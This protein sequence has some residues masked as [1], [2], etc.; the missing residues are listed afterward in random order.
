MDSAFFHIPRAL[1]PA[2]IAVLTCWSTS[3][4]AQ[5]Y[6][7]IQVQDAE[8]GRGVPLVEL[9]TVNKMRYVTDSA[10]RVA[11]L[12]PGL[13]G[14][15]VFF[16][17]HAHGYEVP[18]DGFGI[19][20]ARLKLEEGGSVV[21]KLKRKNLAERLYRCTGYG[22]YRDS[23]LLGKS[24]PVAEPLGAGMVAGQDSVLAV[25]YREK[26]Y[27]FWG[28]TGRMSYP[29]GLFR[30]AGATS[31]LPGKGGLAPSIGVNLKYFTAKDGFCRAMADVPN[32]EGV[33][34]I[35]GVCTVR[36]E[37][38]RERLV[39]H[40]SRRKGLDGEYEHGM[41][42]YNDEREIFEVTT[43]LPLTER[44]RHLA[45]QPTKVKVDGREFIYSGGPVLNVRV[46]ATLAEVMDP[47]KYEAWSCVP[48]S[49]PGS[50]WKWG[51]ANP[52]ASKEESRWLKEGKI[53]AADVR[54]YPEDADKPGRRVQLHS[55]SVRWNAHRQRWI[56]IAVEFA[57]VDKDSPSPLGEVWYS[58]AAKPEGPFTKAVRVVTHNKQT[59]Y[60]PVHHW[61]FDEQGGRVIYFEGTYTNSFVGSPPTPL[62]EYNQVMYRLDLDT[63]RLREVFAR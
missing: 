28:D 15:T 27:W 32:P 29:L 48:Q 24:V 16:D 20:G 47:K 43:T 19:A 59:F 50:D 1:I 12:E 41:M 37:T 2:V 7:E 21:V 13:M 35:D 62:Y 55:G 4:R 17:L 38:G 11:F 54:Y 23:V 30:M 63:P 56:L 49:G 26:L 9:V 40:F 46:P 18:K 10:G 31:D 61:F 6:C 42:L 25:P 8:T 60:N 52:V 53:K 58:E 51:S 36:D 34:W 5:K 45:G 14:Q 33:V 39:G 22:V 44:W 3:T 57:Y